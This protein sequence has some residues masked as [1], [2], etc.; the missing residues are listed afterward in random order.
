MSDNP[1]STAVEQAKVTPG[2][3]VAQYQ[4]D[5]ALVLPSHVKP[6]QFVRIAQGVLRRDRKLAQVAANNVGSFMSALLQCARLGLEPGDTYHLV[7]YGNEIVGITDYTGELEL[8]YRTGAVSSVKA[9]VVYSGDTFRYVPGEMDR[10]VHEPDWF[11]DRG[12]MAG[13]YAYAVMTD[14]AVSRVVMMSKAEVEEAKAVSKTSSRSDSPWNKWPKSMWLKTAI[15]Q[16]YKWVPSSPEF[17]QEL[18]RATA[19]VEQVATVHQLPAPVPDFEPPA[20]VDTATGEVLEAEIVDDP[21]DSPGP[22][23]SADFEPMTTAQN[24][25]IHACL[26]EMEVANDQRHEWA[27]TALGREITSFNEITKR[28]AMRLIDELEAA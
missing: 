17:R 5:I 21:G 11:G 16:L 8:I 14:G 27:S 2:Q 6:E 9:E 10:P 24:R 25:K 1:T 22:G 7:A 4:P 18:A 28:E 15:H 13:V 20:D 26:R 3:L 12:E 23:P 19:A